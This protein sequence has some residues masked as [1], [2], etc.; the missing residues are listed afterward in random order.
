MISHMS[1]VSAEPSD[2][3]PAPAAP[4]RERGRAAS[5]RALVNAAIDLIAEHGPNSVTVR[6]IAQ[7]AGVNHGL[8]HHYFGSKAG[9]IRAVLVAMAERFR[10]E[11]ERDSTG[12]PML[13]RNPELAALAAKVSARMMLD[14]VLTAS[15][16]G[17]PAVQE[18]RK[19]LAARFGL[20]G[21]ELQ[22]L[23]AQAIA[24]TTAWMLFEPQLLRSVGLDPDDAEKWRAQLPLAI[25]R[26]ATAPLGRS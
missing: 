4:R 22:L 19:S 10:E 18:V 3:A 16:L 25:A 17:F 23:T 26:L 1:N 7:R 24:I 5:E 8:V 2:Q 12:V 14:G 20:E 9:L 6:T 21:E 15:E 13:I 11:F